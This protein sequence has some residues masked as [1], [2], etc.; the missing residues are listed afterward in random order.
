MTSK[1]FISHRSTDNK[2]AER[3]FEHL[4]SHGY[5]KSRL[6][7]DF[8][9]KSGLLA[10]YRWRQQLI[11]ELDNCCCLIVICTNQWKESKWCFLESQI[12]SSSG[13][14]C[15]PLVVDQGVDLQESGLDELQGIPEYTGSPDQLDRIVSLLNSIGMEAPSDKTSVSRGWE[16]H[17]GLGQDAL[18]ALKDHVQQDRVKVAVATFGILAIL[19]MVMFLTLMTIQAN[20]GERISEW[21]DV[22]TEANS[23]LTTDQFL[24]R[25]ST[26]S[27]RDDWPPNTRVILDGCGNV[28]S[29]S[30][31]RIR[32]NDLT[33]VY[34]QS[35][36]EP[37]QAP[38]PKRVRFSCVI[39]RFDEDPTT[40]R[41]YIYVERFRL[42]D[43]PPDDAWST[44]TSSPTNCE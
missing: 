16:I 37:V 8:D 24:E 39:D 29:S 3:I 21:A 43:D 28:Y 35:I 42:L 10:G 20:Y 14:P 26:A 27:E 15:I 44:W 9:A 25:I 18:Q 4:L 13:R 31:Q 40:H 19:A 5:P 7:L 22:R 11:R 1:I 36:D 12:V 6:F 33:W 17:S 38:L 32:I 34:I 23:D 30:R 2:Y 41:L